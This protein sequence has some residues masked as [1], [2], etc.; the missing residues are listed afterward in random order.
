VNIAYAAKGCILK[1]AAVRD[2]LC[3]HE[4]PALVFCASRIGVERLSRYLRVALGTPEIRFYHA[5][6]ERAEKTAVEQWFFA[7]TAGVLVSTCAYGMGVDKPNI[8]TVVHRDLPPSVEAYLQESGRAGRDGALARAFLLW[9][10]EDERA[11]A[12]ADGESERERIRAVA[13]F[14]RDHTR[15]R[16]ETLL[17]LLNYAGEQS[18]PETEC[19]DVCAGTARAAL[20]EEASLVDFFRR[21]AR[22]FTCDEAARILAASETTAISTRE[23][24]TAVAYLVKTGVLREGRFFPWR[25]KI[26]VPPRQKI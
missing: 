16:R 25:R 4:K 17:S 15:C 8:R 10:P 6:L 7:S 26:S 23:A 20:R 5:G 24:K 2:L 1:D 21:N 18:K 3:A 14:A 12:R 9:G 11:I 22:A 13:A 19:C